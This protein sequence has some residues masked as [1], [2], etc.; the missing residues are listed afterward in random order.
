MINDMA[1]EEPRI[2]LSDIGLK[3]NYSGL[4]VTQ[5]PGHTR[6]FLKV[7]DGC[8][9]FCSYCI[10]PYARGRSRSLP[11]EDVMEQIC[12]LS[13]SGYR[14]IVLTGIHLGHYG[15]DLSPGTSL[16]ELLKKIEDHNAIERLRISSIEPMEV[17]DEMIA[18]IKD[19]S[20]ICRHLH[21]PMQSGDN[22]ILNSMKRNYDT[23]RFRSRIEKIIN[24]IPGMAIGIDV[25]VGFPGEGEEEFKNTREFIESMPLAYLHVFPYSKRPG[26]EASTLPDHVQ[27][28]L[29]KERGK[30]LRDIGKRKR[31]EYNR[32]F[33]GKELS[34]LVENTKDRETGS[35]KGFSDN[36]IP[37]LI[38]DINL[39]MANHI[40]GVTAQSLMGGKI[41]G[42]K[43]TNSR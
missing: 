20:I 24:A 31:I 32:R 37:V 39:S 40:L 18:H 22:K 38:P 26:T 10:I 27:E 29:K 1:R 2:I 11:E 25:L 9:S 4:P 7:Q 34:V 5:F 15:H 36:Y 14:E 6:A 33:I 43:I 17:T 23:D 21:I 41:V 19:S 35:M 42:R 16:L 30:I 8:N 13:S 28:S 12:K 3:K